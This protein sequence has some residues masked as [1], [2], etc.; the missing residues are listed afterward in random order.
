M[1]SLLD[2]I[3]KNTTIRETDILTESKFFNE[4]D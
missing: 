1:S 4:K 2:K 3:K